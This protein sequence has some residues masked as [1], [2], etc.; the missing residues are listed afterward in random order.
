MEKEAKTLLM[1]MVRGQLPLRE[2]Q[3]SKSRTTEDPSFALSKLTDKMKLLHRNGV[4]SAISLQSRQIA[5]KSIG[6]RVEA[7]AAEY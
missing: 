3:V 6:A 2:I 7:G 5:A 4:E 1:T